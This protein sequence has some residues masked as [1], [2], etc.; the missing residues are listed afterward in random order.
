M[1]L[2]LAIARPLLWLPSYAHE[3]PLGLVREA[4]DG[5]E[6]RPDKV[7]RRN[8]RIRRIVLFSRALKAA[9]LYL[10]GGIW[11]AASGG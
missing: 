2:N 10:C 9:G 3:L 4:V 5:G 1:I 8:V 7:R 11:Q 6:P